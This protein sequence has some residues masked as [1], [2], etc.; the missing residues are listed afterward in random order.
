MVGGGGGGR[1]GVRGVWGIESTGE[2]V[3]R[4]WR[5]GGVGEDDRGRGVVGLHGRGS[6]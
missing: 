4:R 1:V 3:R 6:R 2:A 5:E